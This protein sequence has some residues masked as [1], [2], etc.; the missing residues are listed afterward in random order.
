MRRDRWIEILLIA[1]FAACVAFQ[2]FVPPSV[3]M[4]NNGDFARL[5]GRFSLGPENRDASDEYHYFTKHWIYH[6]SYQWVSDNFSSE[7]IPIG[8]ALLYGWIF[9]SYHFN[10]R[11]LGAIHALL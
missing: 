3:G 10:I 4:A 11:I 5:I 6:R 9:D 2:L 8:A 1:L 7:L